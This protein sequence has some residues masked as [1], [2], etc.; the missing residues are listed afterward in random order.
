MYVS[1]VSIYLI[2]I[3]VCYITRSYAKNILDHI[4][5]NLY[6]NLTI[7]MKNGSLNPKLLAMVR[8]G[9]RQEKIAAKRII[10]PMRGLTGRLAKW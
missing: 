7:G 8:T 1:K 4:T 10:F 3:N 9:L 5:L 2:H 6:L